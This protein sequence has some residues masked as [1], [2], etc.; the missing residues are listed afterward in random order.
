[1]QTNVVA[2]EGYSIIQLIASVD[3]LLAVR[4]DT[5]FI[6]DLGLDFLNPVG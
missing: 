1:M 6:T 4:R 3:K 2:G 5:L